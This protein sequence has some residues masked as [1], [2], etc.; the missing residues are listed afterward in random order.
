MPVVLPPLFLAVAR[1]CVKNEKLVLL[2]LRLTFW[3]Q[4]GL[5]A[6]QYYACNF[7][8]LGKPFGN[9]SNA[10]L[11]GAFIAALLP[12]ALVKWSKWEAAL[13]VL[14]CLACDSSMTIA[15]MLAGV[16]T[17]FW[18]KYTWRSL[19]IMV[20]MF[21]ASF[22]FMTMVSILPNHDMFNLNGRMLPWRA[23][24]EAF[25]QRPSGWGPGAWLG[26]DSR[27]NINYHE[28]YAQVHSDWLQLLMEGGVFTFGLIIIFTIHVFTRSKPMWLGCYAALI[29]NCLANFPLHFFPTAFLMALA[30]AALYKHEG[31]RLE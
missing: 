29:V 26:I 15:A 14:V 24:W 3:F 17:Y 7:E 31:E 27:W 22:C 8:C 13:V 16:A 20:P 19:S 9:L 23:A 12:I 30:I 2:G 5:M 11:M 18:F 4:S 25:L 28:L 6:T 21:L 1:E 10:T